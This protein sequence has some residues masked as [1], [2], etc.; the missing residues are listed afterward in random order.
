MSATIIAFPSAFNDDWEV[1]DEDICR[2]DAADIMK[3]LADIVCEVQ[4]MRTP[5]PAAAYPLLVALKNSLPEVTDAFEDATVT[6][7]L[8]ARG[9]DDVLEAADEAVD[10]RHAY[11]ASNRFYRLAA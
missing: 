3:R 2:M 8:T 5:V 1:N 7:F 11:L 4:T 9:I 6:G 10:E